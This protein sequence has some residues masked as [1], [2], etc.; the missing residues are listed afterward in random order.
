[1][2]EYHIGRE[3]YTLPEE[4]PQPG[5]EFTPVGLRTRR[6]EAA[7]KRRKR[8]R[9]IYAIAAAALVLTSVGPF[10]LFSG[11]GE[12]APPAPGTQQIH[13][14]G[15]QTTPGGKQTTPGGAAPTAKPGSLWP[16]PPETKAADP[17]L[18]ASFTGK[19]GDVDWFWLDYNADFLPAEDDETVYD[20]EV[21]RF[22]ISC[23][24]K[25]GAA[26]ETTYVSASGIPDIEPAGRGFHFHYDGPANGEFP[27]GTDLIAI[28]MQ[29]RDR[30][31]DTIYEVL[32]ETAA[33]P[34]APDYVIP[35]CEIYVISHFSEFRGRLLFQGLDNADKVLLQY[36]DPETD[37]C[38]AEFDIT[39]AALEDG[40][41]N[42]EP[43]STD[44][45][46]ELHQAYYEAQNS[47]PMKLHIK[48]WI[49]YEGPEGHTLDV[50]EADSI[51]EGTWDVF[52]ND[53]TQTGWGEWNPPGCF[54]VYF[55]DRPEFSS[56]LY[57]EEAI[58]GGSNVLIVRMRIDGEDVDIDPA[59]LTMLHD[60]FDAKVYENGELVDHHYHTSMLAIPRPAGYEEGE[61]HVANFT[62][63][64]YLDAAEKAVA[65]EQDI[66][67]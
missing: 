23:Y 51:E 13:P 31:T 9:L 34:E 65:F 12:A 63:I 29:V 6:D 56:V 11:S 36:W 26:L 17:E 61:G 49:G 48:V 2:G 24:D 54:Q 5:P 7:E 58:P 21:H 55:K 39:K 27:E 66:E 35:D 67:F 4:F 46:Y 19:T 8:K 14:G 59:Q 22:G 53:S 3:E 43:F 30:N 1:M 16:A 25:F 57:D 32:T 45:V 50:F 41:Y 62:I 28:W 15:T 18:T 64:Q 52:Y 42:I 47:F 40:T 60:E 10:R 38:D 37:S 33:P 20:L 44:F